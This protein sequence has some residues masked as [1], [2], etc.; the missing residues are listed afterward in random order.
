M[1]FYVLAFYPNRRP[2]I[3]EVDQETWFEDTKK[4]RNI[5]LWEHISL[6][7]PYHFE[8]FDLWC[9]EEFLLKNPTDEDFNLIP[10]L[11]YGGE[12][13][14]PCIMTINMNFDSRPMTIEE[15]YELMEILGL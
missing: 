15:I 10:S 5:D 8:Q 11:L 7:D 14:G 9:D 12:I 6:R 3:E 2:E 13:Y 4:K 1:K